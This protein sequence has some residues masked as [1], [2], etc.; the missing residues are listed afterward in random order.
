[1]RRLRR[2]LPSA[3]TLAIVGLV[4]VAV[5]AGAWLL[6]R[7]GGDGEIVAAGDDGIAAAATVTP[8]NHLFGDPI[9][10][11]VEVLLDRDRFDPERVRVAADFSPYEQSEAIRRTRQDV[12]SVT[13]LVYTV[14]IR[15]LTQAC[16]PQQVKQAYRFRPARVLYD[17]P[18]RLGRPRLL[19]RATWPRVEISSRLRESQIARLR[20]GEISTDQP[21]I[22]LDWRADLTALREPTFRFSPV[23][24]SWV[25]FAAAALLLLLAG[26]L[27]RGA[28]KAPLTRAERRLLRMSPLE[29]AL[30]LVDRAGGRE[31]AEARLALDRLA[32]ELPSEEGGLD[33]EARQLAWSER[34]PG[35]EDASNLAAR[36]RERLNGRRSGRRR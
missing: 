13:R 32:A 36:V 2:L 11:R 18:E 7:D 35:F 19:A 29:R 14:P 10:G 20:G 34:D 31:A 23:T 28:V 3:A 17:D 5:L 4:A 16:F 25:L 27:V 21:T 9:T 26:L 6:L 15:C 12:G 1:V 33:Q 24:G 8:V 22:E 30:L